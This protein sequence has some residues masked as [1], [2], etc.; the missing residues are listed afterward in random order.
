MFI[1]NF[2]KS[3]IIPSKM[4]KYRSMSLI[5]AIAI[6]LLS[7][8]VL[9]FPQ[10]YIISRDRYRLVD[11]QNAYLLQVFQ[12]LDET[13]LATLRNTGGRVENG[14]MTCS[15]TVQEGEPYIFSVVLQDQNYDLYIVFDLYDVT[16]P[17]AQPTYNANERFNTL[18][19][20]EGLERILVIFYMQQ[21]AYK[22]PSL[23]IV[24]PYTNTVS[25]D[26]STME[27]GSLLSYRIMDMFIPT[28]KGENT[29]MTFISC[30]VFPFLIILI[31]WIL[32]KTSG[33]TFT[34]KEFYN[35]GAIA[36]I[37]PLVVVFILSWIFPRLTFMQYYST[38]FGLFYLIMIF[39]ITAKTRIS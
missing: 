36:S 23:T 21:I 4:A 30:V 5:I 1:V 28:I 3:L 10:S 19:D 25:F 6:F 20:I 24:L 22:T 31:I 38:A 17:D 37:I 26:L 2:L 29:F 34:L 18:E 12:E 9:A 39:R 15:G 32:F 11:E 27:D 16:D 7:S 35:I 14:V 8:Y 33:T 13:D